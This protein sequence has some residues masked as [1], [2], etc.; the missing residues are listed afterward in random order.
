M[1]DLQVFNLIKSDPKRGANFLL[2]DFEAMM[3]FMNAWTQKNNL[4][5]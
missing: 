1:I 3:K 4:R 2:E 5:L